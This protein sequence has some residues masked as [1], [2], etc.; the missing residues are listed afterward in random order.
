MNRLY[1]KYFKRLLDI[2]L[3]FIGLIILIPMWILIG[4]LVFIDSGWPILFSQKR[5]GTNGKVFNMIKFRTMVRGADKIKENY[6][7]LNQADGP[8]FKIKEDPRFTRLGKLL[9]HIGLDEIPQFVNIIKGDMSLVGPRPLPVNEENKIE[10]QYRTLRQ[11]VRPGL[12]SSWL[13]NGSH[14]LSFKQW[15]EYDL[16]DVQ[17]ASLVYDLKIIFGGLLVVVDIANSKL[18]L[19]FGSKK[20][21]I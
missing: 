3:A 9:S 17:N 13:V 5:V 7:H 19:I 15:M 11:T 8:V 6:R 4:M 12:L 2:G 20:Q 10:S 21:K 1:I 18:D 16:K 14:S